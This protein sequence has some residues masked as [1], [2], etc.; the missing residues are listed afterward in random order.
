ML[1]WELRLR[2]RTSEKPRGLGRLS[3]AVGVF[4]IKLDRSE[5]EH[6]ARNDGQMQN[7]L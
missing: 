5:F 7:G 3:P 4:L 1:W 6:L 2:K